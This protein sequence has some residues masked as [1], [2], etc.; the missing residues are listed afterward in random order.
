MNILNRIDDFINESMNNK[1]LI[2]YRL[3]DPFGN[4]STLSVLLKP[5]SS[6]YYVFYGG[7]Q[8]D[9]MPYAIS[10]LQM[11][12]SLPVSIK[13][14]KTIAMLDKEITTA[15]K[16]GV[17]DIVKREVINKN[18]KVPSSSAQDMSVDSAIKMLKTLA[19][20]QIVSI[21]IK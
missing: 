3:K 15:I 4:K 2:I 11:K 9:G 6:L 19:P 17:N 16:S 14:F 21:S 8:N 5:D 7:W 1:N 18:L 13:K 20:N 10:N 12:K